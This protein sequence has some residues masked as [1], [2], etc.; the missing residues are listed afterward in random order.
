[1]KHTFEPREKGPSPRLRKVAENIYQYSGSRRSDYARFR[2]KGQC[3]IQALGSR[4]NPCTS[5]PEAKRLLREMKNDLD[6]TEQT[7]I[8][9]NFAQIITEFEQVLG[10]AKATLKYKKRYLKQLKSDFPVPMTTR[11]GEIKKSHIL[12]FMAIFKEATADHYNHVFT[13]VRAIFDYAV[14]DR[15]IAVSPADG[16]KYRKRQE[17]NKKLIPT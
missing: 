4:A 11:V 9:K 16:I 10:G 5:L 15:A 2:H 14:A 13:L 1:M 6:A 12:T 3:I 7:A 8:R 17:T